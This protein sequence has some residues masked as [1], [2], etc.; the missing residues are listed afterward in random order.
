MKGFLSSIAIAAVLMIAGLGS[1]TAEAPAGSPAARE[2]LLLGVG[3]GLGEISCSGERCN[4][5]T[6]AA[7]IDVHVGS[8]VGSR[9]AFGVELWVMAHNADGFTLTHAIGTVGMRY[10]L[11]PRLWIQGGAGVA[12]GRRRY[13]ARV[14]ELQ[15]QTDYVPAIMGAA[16][17]ELV[18][19][20]RFAMDLQLRGGTGFYSSD[21]IRAHNVAVGLGFTWY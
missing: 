5:V 18:V 17:Y 6:E 10:W 12:Q 19:G 14:I 20:R 16:G 13:D 9:A 4:G 1:A 21:T 2:G 7:G 11:L 3:L 15:D 8:M